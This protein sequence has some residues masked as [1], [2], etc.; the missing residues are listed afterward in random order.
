ML[1]PQLYL[2]AELA[3]LPTIDAVKEHAKSRRVMSIEP[4]MVVPPGSSPSNRVLAYAGDE[5]YPDKS[6]AG[7]KGAR[8]RAYVAAEKDKDGRIRPVQPMQ[9]VGVF[10]RNVEGF[11]NMLAGA[12]PDDAAKEHAAKAKL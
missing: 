11:D 2:L 3:N 10:R 6:L 9:V 7:P 1:P 12:V 5:Y 4:V 8:H